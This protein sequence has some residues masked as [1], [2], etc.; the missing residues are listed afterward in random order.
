MTFHQVPTMKKC[1]IIYNK[2]IEHLNLFMQDFIVVKVVR[3][4][5][6]EIANILL[7]KF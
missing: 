6:A 5:N 2:N 4:K 7:I 1:R 3:N